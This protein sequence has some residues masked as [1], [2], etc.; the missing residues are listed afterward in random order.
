MDSH[1]VNT[2]T[3]LGNS[4]PA[5]HTLDQSWLEISYFRPKRLLLR[6]SDLAH[7]TTYLEEG[8]VQI[9][10]QEGVDHLLWQYQAGPGCVAYHYLM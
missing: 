6:H 3:N 5:P 1:E 7:F 9:S 2:G 4:S 10:Y 8:L